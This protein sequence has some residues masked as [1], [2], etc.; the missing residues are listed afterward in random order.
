[1]VHGFANDQA[2]DYEFDIVLDYAIHIEYDFA[3]AFT[4]DFAFDLI[5]VITFSPSFYYSIEKIV[6]HGDTDLL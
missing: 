6:E 2:Y 1:M 5:I 4:H 3:F